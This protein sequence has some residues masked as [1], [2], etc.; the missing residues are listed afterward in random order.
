MHDLQKIATICLE[1]VR[2]AGIAPGNISRFAVNPRFTRK[3]GQCVYR[4]CTY[5]I[6]IAPFLLDSS[7]PVDVLKNTLIHEILHSCKGCMNHGATWKAHADRINA[8]YGYSI[9]RLVQAEEIAACKEAGTYNY[10]PRRESYKYTITCNGCGQT[11]KRKRESEFARFPNMWHCG[12][13]G[14]AD[15]SRTEL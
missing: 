5:I 4:S 13:C 3:W 14:R 9:S 15:W 1:E 12:R 11:I 2:A 7:T 8:R 6:E 10:T